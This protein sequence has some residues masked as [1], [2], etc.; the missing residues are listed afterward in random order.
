MVGLNVD[1][2]MYEIVCG[3]ADLEGGWFVCNELYRDSAKFV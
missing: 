3:V 1:K 2:L